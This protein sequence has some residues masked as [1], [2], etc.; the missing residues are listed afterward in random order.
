M[1]VL[2][3]QLRPHH[4]LAAEVEVIWYL[5]APVALLTGSRMTVETQFPEGK[6]QCNFSDAW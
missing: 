6:W 3:P 2:G 5:I 1:G 4:F